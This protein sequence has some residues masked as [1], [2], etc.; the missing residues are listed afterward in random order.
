MTE[1]IKIGARAIKENSTSVDEVQRCLEELDESI[2]T[3]KEVDD[4]LGIALAI[5]KYQTCIIY[6]SK[7]G[8]QTHLATT[9]KY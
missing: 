4:V 3:Q 5:I 1:A 8:I 6:T 7:L 9:I 2:A